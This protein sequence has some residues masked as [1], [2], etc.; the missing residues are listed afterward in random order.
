M[1]V[2]SLLR[3]GGYFGTNRQFYLASVGS[4]G[5][6]CPVVGRVID[7]HGCVHRA[8][9]QQKLSEWDG[10]CLYRKVRLVGG[11]LSAPS[12]RCTAGETRC[13]RKKATPNDGEFIQT[14][15]HRVDR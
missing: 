1:Q 14:V 9:F 10:I 4:L 8:M 11:I 13:S 15:F 2:A 12:L 6:C 5:Q 3:R 7:P